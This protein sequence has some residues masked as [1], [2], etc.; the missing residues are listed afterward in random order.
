M[1]VQEGRHGA[2]AGWDRAGGEK[3]SEHISKGESSFSLINGRYER[4]KS[5]MIPR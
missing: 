5:R 1:L 3:W 2:G 4:E